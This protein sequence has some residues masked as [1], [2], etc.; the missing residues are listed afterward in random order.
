MALRHGYRLN[1]R[2]D[3]IWIGD[4]A[5]QNVP[6]SAREDWEKDGDAVHL[7][8]YA[9]AGEPEVFTFRALNFTERQ[10][11]MGMMDNANLGPTFKQAISFCF[12]LCVR[13]PAASES[14]ASQTTGQAGMKMLERVAGMTVLSEGFAGDLLWQY[15]DMVDFYGLKIWNA[16]FPTEPEKKASSPPPTPPQSSA[17]ASSTAG[18]EATEK[19]AEAG[20]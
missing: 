2:R 14:Y 1:D 3:T 15:P 10:Y 16:S 17:V 11:V 20:A 12:R 7:R 9:T 8:N 4:P 19:P 13:F 5:L 18:T 6:D